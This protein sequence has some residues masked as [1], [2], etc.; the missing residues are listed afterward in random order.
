MEE[1]YGLLT[2]NPIPRAALP[3]RVLEEMTAKVTRA[4]LE[5]VNK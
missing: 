1:R 3:R 4:G 5:H 2:Q